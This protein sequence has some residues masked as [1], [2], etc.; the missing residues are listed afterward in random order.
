VAALPPLPRRLG[1]RLCLDFANTV[2]D[3]ASD[4]PQELLVSPDRLVDWALDAGALSARPLRLADSALLQRTLALREAFRRVLVRDGDTDDLRNV[5][6]AIGAAGLH[7]VLR[8]VGDAFAWAWDANHPEALFWAVA[9]DMGTLLT[10]HPTL[11]RVRTCALDSC[12]WLFLDQSR[13]HSRRWCS[14][15]GCGNVAKSRAFQTRHRA[16]RL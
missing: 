5:N 15:E 11:E 16:Q 6:D 9:R 14:M 12:G 13:N 2:E 4:H 3:R 8:P 7:A 1:G 10:D